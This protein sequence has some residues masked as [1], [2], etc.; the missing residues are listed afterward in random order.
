MVSGTGAW[1]VFKISAIVALLAIAVEVLGVASHSQSPPVAS[2]RERPPLALSVR[3]LNKPHLNPSVRLIDKVRRLQHLM[4]DLETPK[5]TPSAPR[6]YSCFIAV[7]LICLS[8]VSPV[9]QECKRRLALKVHHIALRY[10]KKEL[11]RMLV[12][13]FKS[14]VSVFRKELIRC[15]ALGLGE[16]AVGEVVSVAANEIRASSY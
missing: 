7:I 11:K 8:L 2:P 1:Q 3:C 6:Y 12:R 10:A 15:I 16:V 9:L 5:P 4:S 14:F 13:S